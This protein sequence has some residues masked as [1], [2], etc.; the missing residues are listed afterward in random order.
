MHGKDRASVLGDKPVAAAPLNKLQNVK[1]G[2]MMILDTA[3]D[4]VALYN[5][6]GPLQYIYP[7]GISKKD[8]PAPPEAWKES[9]ISYKKSQQ[10]K[11]PATVPMSVW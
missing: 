7:N 10:D 6:N 2:G 11:T 4:V 5:P 1:L 3:S 8:A 9:V